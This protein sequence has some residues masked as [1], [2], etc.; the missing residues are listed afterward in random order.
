[1]LGARLSF[2]AAYFLLLARL[3]GIQQFGMFSGIWALL[4][5]LATFTG[6][7]FPVLVFRTMALSPDAAPDCAGRGFRAMFWT[8]LPLL[9][10][11]VLI[12]FIA[13]PERPDFT[14]IGAL[15]ISEIIAV[16]VVTLLSSLY[17]GNERL[18]RSQ[19]VT[20]TLW[21]ARLAAILLTTLYF[22]R[23]DLQLAAKIHACTTLLVA[24]GWLIVEKRYIS[25][26]F[27]VQNPDRHEVFMGISF[28]I[29]GAATI[30]FTELNQSF[31]LAQ[32]GA[33]SAGVLAVAYKL[34]AVSSAPL[35]ALCQAVAPRLLRAAHDGPTHLW[36]R[37]KTLILPMLAFA[38]ACILA[39]SLGSRL[40]SVVFG[41][42]Y[43]PSEGIARALAVLPIFTAFRLLSVYMLMAAS[44]QHLR[45]LSEIAC[46]TLGLALNATLIAIWGL[47]GAIA[48]ILLTESIAAFIM[49]FL[50]FHTS[51]RPPP[52]SA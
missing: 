18:G 27:T 33:V 5:F 10:L 29:S 37:G 8:A 36:A 21:L 44:K 3:L 23:I 15:A 43:A 14:T 46:L 16:P 1:M 2:Q 9:L 35:S 13:F 20:A 49:G 22:H 7:G 47:N 39:I 30:A 51:R 6:L 42:A 40:L 19:L 41:A 28:A 24:I 38:L 4:G 11:A 25:S 31:V 17:Q 34:V 52:I 26:P 45:V 48:A 32:V 12:P 50:A